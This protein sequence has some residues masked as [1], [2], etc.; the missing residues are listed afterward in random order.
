MTGPGLVNFTG[1]CTDEPESFFQRISD[2]S[3]AAS[4]AH[5]ISGGALRKDEFD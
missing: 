1:L 2:V 5:L 4:V 3:Y